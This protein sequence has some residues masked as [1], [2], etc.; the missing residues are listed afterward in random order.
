MTTTPFGDFAPWA[1]SNSVGGGAGENYPVQY[2][3]WNPPVYITP[4]YVTY[5]VYY[6]PNPTLENEVREL[7][8]EIKKLR[9]VI[10]NG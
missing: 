8:E 10:E 7:K 6:Y 2:Y 1:I 3:S 5:P 4:T 9:K